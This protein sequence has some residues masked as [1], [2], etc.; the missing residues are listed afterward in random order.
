VRHGEGDKGID[1]GVALAHGSGGPNDRRAHGG[2]L[3][4][5]DTRAKDRLHGGTQQPVLSLNRM[6]RGYRT[7]EG[8]T[9]M[10]YSLFGCRSDH[11]AVLLNQL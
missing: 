3:G 10:P 4:P 9:S 5:L 1:R 11:A 2:N 8:I 6:A 7:V